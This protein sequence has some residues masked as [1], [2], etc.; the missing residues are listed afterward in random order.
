MFLAGPLLGLPLAAL[1]ATAV[2]VAEAA[3]GIRVL[4][5]I[6]EGYDASTEG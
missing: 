1:A 3:L 4:G 5:R 6:L 2:L